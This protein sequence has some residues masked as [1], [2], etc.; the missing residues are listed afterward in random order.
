MSAR[1]KHPSE[2]DVWAPLRASDAN[3]SRLHNG[4]I[5]SIEP[6]TG[7]MTVNV[8][9]GVPFKTAIPVELSANSSAATWR[10]HMPVVGAAV[11]VEFDVAD[12]PRV[13]AYTTYEAMTSNSSASANLE[14]YAAML[15]RQPNV[16]NL[17]LLTPLSAGEF[18]ERSA[19]GAY[20]KGDNSGKLTLAGRAEY[21]NINGGRNEISGESSLYRLES[22]GGYIRFGETRAMRLPPLDPVSDLLFEQPLTPAGSGT[23]LDVL[24]PTR[25]RFQLGDI[26]GTILPGPYSAE[27]RMTT[28]STFL[29]GQPVVFS[30][31]GYAGA[32]VTPSASPPPD[33]PP[34]GLTTVHKALEDFPTCTIEGTSNGPLGNLAL[35][36][37]QEIAISSP[38][39]RIGLMPAST[40]QPVARAVPVT[41]AITAIMACLTAIKGAIGGLATTPGGVAAAG[42]ITGAIE[43]C[44]QTVV[45]AGIIATITSPT[46]FVP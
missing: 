15:A 1:I 16:G 27:P 17:A 20:I 5:T 22:R 46:V 33:V 28:T 14:G 30:L 3:Y 37:T 36:A 35:T 40:I 9:N 11:L 38:A 19:G 2:V 32:T 25:A 31:R 43:A 41:T 24:S 4:R 21:L 44:E 42:T 7:V 18:D 8:E 6:R 12:Q 45:S 23:M 26:R 34:A 29:P 10:R 13:V 39:V